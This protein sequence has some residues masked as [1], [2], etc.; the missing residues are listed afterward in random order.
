MPS[1]LP[2]SSTALELAIEQSNA[3]R[4]DDLDVTLLKKL[5]S[6]SECPLHMLP[7]LAW[8]RSVDV[9]RD[10]WPE[11]VKRRAIAESRKIHKTKGTAGAVRRAVSVFGA[12][13]QIT[14]WWQ[15][16]PTGAPYTF[17]VEYTPSAILP[18]DTQF[19]NDIITAINRAKNERSS[20][21]VIVKAP[22]TIDIYYSAQLRTATHARLSLVEP[23][24]DVPANAI[25]FGGVPIEFNGQAIEFEFLIT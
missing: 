15:E 11:D 17:V 8:A 1:L 22:I 5:W 24:S 10:D 9:W 25:T 14:E 18:N 16:T 2:P 19:Q 12:G 23:P 7:W 20:F 3:E 13:I 4:M 6:A 21:S